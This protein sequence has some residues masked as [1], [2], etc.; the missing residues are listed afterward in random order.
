MWNYWGVEAALHV[1]QRFFVLR[2][3]GVTLVEKVKITDVR[4]KFL[5]EHFWW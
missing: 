3:F 1:C 4:K 2:S 5:P